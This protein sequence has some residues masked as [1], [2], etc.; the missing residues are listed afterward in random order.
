[1]RL[2][3]LELV[4]FKSFANR[5]CL[6]FGRGITAI[7]GPNGS[8]KSNISDAVR[9][10][11]GEQSARSLRGNKMEDVIFSGS[12]GKKPLGMAEVQLTL[13]NSDGFL[14]IDFSEVT[15]TRRVYRSGESEF[16]INGKQCRLRDIQDLF[17]DTGLGREG[18]AIIGQG[19]IDAVLSVRS[20]DRRVVLEETAGIVKYRLRKEEALQKIEQTNQDLVRVTDILRELE[21]RLGPLQK[22]AEKARRYQILGEKLLLAEQDYFALELQRLAGEQSQLEAERRALLETAEK[23]Q[24]QQGKL[25]EATARLDQRLNQVTADL[26][27]GQARQVQLA[28]EQNALES[29][30]NVNRE[31]EKNNEQRLHVLTQLR[32]EKLSQLQNFQAQ[33]SK[34]LDEL[35]RALE[36]CRATAELVDRAAQTLKIKQEERQLLQDKIETAKDEFFEFMRALA[37]L[38]NFQRNFEKEAQSLDRQIE[39]QKEAA[40]AS[41]AA[42]EKLRAAIQKTKE[43]R[44]AQLQERERGK[45]AE[46]ALREKQQDL[47]K[48]VALERERLRKIQSETTQLQT[49]LS[50][51][52]ELDEDYEGYSASVRRLMQLETY[53][54]LILGTVADVLTVPPGLELAFEVALGSALQNIITPN[55]AAAQTLIQ[56]LKDNKAGRATFLPLDAMRPNTFPPSARAALNMPGVLGTGDELAECQERFRPVIASLLGRTVFTEDLDSAVVLRRRLKQFSR[57]VTRDGSVVYP[58]GAMTGGSQTTRTSGLLSRKTEIAELETKLAARKQV[59]EAARSTVAELELAYA[60]I[61]KRLAA[62]AEQELAAQLAVQRLDQTLE[63]LYRELSREEQQRAEHSAQEQQ[64][65]AAREALLAQGETAAAQLEQEE[66]AEARHRAAI[67]AMEA[68]LRTSEKEIEA[69]QS[70]LTQLQIKLT[71]EKGTAEKIRMQLAALDRQ[72]EE[73]QK[74]LTEAEREKEEL[75]RAQAK[76]AEEMTAAQA[77]LKLNMES[78]QSLA[79]E[80]ERLRQERNEL[81]DQLK[82]HNS[83]LKQVNAQHT[84]IERRLYRNESEFKLKAGEVE[85]IHQLLE[86]RDLNP[87]QVKERKVDAPKEKLR[88]AI[89]ELREEIRGLGVVNPGAPEE[90]EQVKERHHFLTIQL[91]DLNEAKGQ[92]RKVIEEMDEICRAKFEETFAQVRAEFQKLFTELFQGGKADLRLTEPDSPLTTGI[93]IVAQP[94]GKKLQNLLL[95]SGGERAL[96]AIALL[97]AIRRVKPT[98]FCILDEIDAALDEANLHR[99]AKLMREF[100]E[101]TQ[102]LTIT[103]RQ[104]TMEAADALYGVTMTD[105]AVSQIISVRMKQEG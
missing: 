62:M 51:L 66:A 92:L 45:A 83:R 52:R 54:N 68:Q 71:E 28:E 77:R 99:F 53:R 43:Q 93:D 23:I 87:A 78:R 11:L 6:E 29:T 34:V 100:A 74:V 31:R 105:E 91:N 90:Y 72:I 17:T 24:A 10:V 86:E 21:Q 42:V 89:E 9:W 101:T 65:I 59:E 98:P 94:P 2:K 36:G 103:H 60:E 55:E 47:A 8:G 39:A 58:S 85:R 46:V 41:A 1:M 20:Q 104:A 61:S 15:V 63:Q 19:Q 35:Q 96:T 57:I 50:T 25:E 48:Q 84:Q 95:L 44:Q 76:L 80:L 75:R 40:A 82:D 27:A 32:E 102:L 56:W 70:Q 30:V 5:V 7:V 26:E 3:R 37:E 67:Q 64:L 38:R 73:T 13:D 88:E 14:P 97:F 16:L 69:A 81:Q 49:R 12:D 33:R 4:G 22:E 18:Y 79:A